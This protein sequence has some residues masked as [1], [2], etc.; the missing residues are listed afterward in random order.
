MAATGYAQVSPSAS[1]S[2]ASKSAAAGVK[3]RA[4]P[5]SERVVLRVGNAEVTEA[6]FE[7]RIADIEGQPD[8]D[9]EGSLEK[10]RRRL[11]DDYASV[12]MLSQ[13]A[14][15]SHL[16]ATPE[17]RRKLEV[18]RIQ[19]LS[20]AEFASLMNQA[21][22]TQEEVRQY[23]EAHAD[24]YQEV[25]LRRLFIWKRG[26]DTQ[27]R[28]GLAPEAARARADAILKT[29]AEGGDTTQ[30]TEE[31]KKSDAGLLDPKP[32]AFPRVELP[33]AME[34]VAFSAPVGRWSL[35]QD[36]AESII[37]IQLLKRYRQQLGEVASSIE[38]ELQNQT[39][40]AKLNELKKNAGIWMDE[41]YFGTA[42]GARDE[43]PRRS[44]NEPTTLQDPGGNGE[45]KHEKKQ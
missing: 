43:K 25:R 32:L 7:S 1:G 9:K 21:K 12:L 8:R 2:P 6:E 41:Q 16:D 24:E 23:Y 3:K 4:V 20:D 33:P 28:R 13:Q 15:A 26:P 27:N 37:L 36:T 19:I 40:R 39:M 31:F 14:V 29:S 11:G 30:L 10:E 45:G 18:G 22:P 35:V 44:S 42:S 38:Q 34:K 5:A 17:I